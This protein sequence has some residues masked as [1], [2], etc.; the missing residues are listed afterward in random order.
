LNARHSTLTGAEQTELHHAA[1][2]VGMRPQIDVALD[3]TLQ[4]TVGEAVFG[5]LVEALAAYEQLAE[6]RRGQP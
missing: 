3:G 2:A 1:Y 4:F 6:L 5:H